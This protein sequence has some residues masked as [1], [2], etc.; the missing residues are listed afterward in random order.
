MA[1]AVHQGKVKAV[2][3]FGEN[4]VMSDPDST[5]FVHALQELDLLVAQDIFLTE[6]ARLAHVVLPAAGWAEKD[7]TVTNTERRVQR[8]RQ[9]IE[10]PGQA[11]ADWRIWGR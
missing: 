3:V 4:P 5:H 11:K 9:A 2:Y 8:V 6:T 1:D 10:P 7:G